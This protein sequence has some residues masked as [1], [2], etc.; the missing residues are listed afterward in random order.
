MVMITQEF[1][2]ECVYYD[3]YTGHFQWLERPISHFYD[4]ATRNKINTRYAGKRSGSVISNN[5]RRTKYIS[6]CISGQKVMAHRLAWL[7][8]HGRMP[9][10]QIDHINGNGL[11][12]AISNLRE[13]T[14]KTNHM[15]MP[16]QL[17]N[18]SG[19]TGV[20]KHTNVN[21]WV[22][23]IKTNQKSSHLGIFDDWFDAVCCRKSAENRLGFHHNHGR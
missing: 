13:A 4:E 18:K 11:D 2:K 3:P 19:V 20:Y 10:S 15:N 14:N 9:S 8:V 5:G 1:L 22:A 23:Q 16:K 17:N 12:N 6:I 21:R 7:Y